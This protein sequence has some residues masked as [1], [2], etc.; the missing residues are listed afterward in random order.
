[1]YYKNN[2]NIQSPKASY[3][4]YPSDNPWQKQKN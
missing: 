1:M 3:T 2:K 4:M